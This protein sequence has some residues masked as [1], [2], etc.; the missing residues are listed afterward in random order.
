[1]NYSGYSLDRSLLCYIL[2]VCLEG[3]EPGGLATAVAEAYRGP[4]K[5]TKD[6]KLKIY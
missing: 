4:N 6:L 3:V 1:M 5:L 2:M